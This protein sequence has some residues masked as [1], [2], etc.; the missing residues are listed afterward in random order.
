MSHHTVGRSREGFRRSLR[1][2]G[3]LDLRAHPPKKR[4]GEI[5]TVA[6]SPVITMAPTTPVYDAIK[7]M[8]KEG[9]RRI[10]VVDPG[11]HKLQGIVTATDIV[12]Y[13]GGGEKFRMIQ[14]KYAGNFFKAINEPIGSIMTLEA[15]SVLTSS[16]IS[17][18]IEIMKSHGVGGL[19]VVDEENCVWAIVTERDVITLFADRISGAKVVDVMSR[20]VIA[21]SPKASILK[22]ERIMIK[23]GFRRLPLLLDEKLIGVVT[24]MDVLKFFGSGLVFDHLQSGT[25]LQALQT[26]ILEIAVKDVVTTE[27]N[28]DVGQAARVM[29]ERNIG[30]LPV[31]EKEKLVGI[32]TERDFFKL[33][34]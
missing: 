9:F 10:P 15:I 11:T 26:P 4:E 7:I 3:P 20:K 28:A 6:K 19:P 33:I 17:D 8:V 14:R 34:A 27:P 22:A 24:V 23:H 2:R 18:A 29:Q 13:L 31:V 12:N 16:K 5:M 21:V 1:E 30:A 32:V 25:L